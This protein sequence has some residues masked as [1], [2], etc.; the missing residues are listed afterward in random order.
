MW[1]V[2]GSNID[3]MQCTGGGAH[4][5]GFRSTGVSVLV[6]ADCAGLCLGRCASRDPG[7]QE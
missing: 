2:P 4:T 5:K 6:H 1:W 7:A 3:K